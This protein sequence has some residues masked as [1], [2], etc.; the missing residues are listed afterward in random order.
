VLMPADVNGRWV[1]NAVMN[2][3][4]VFGPQSGANYGFVARAAEGL[5]IS[6][7]VITSNNSSG[8]MQKVASSGSNHAVLGPNCSGGAGIYT[9][10]DLGATTSTVF[11]PT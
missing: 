1:T 5:T 2:G 3:N 4:I 8:S 7:N 6:G 9:A 11:S 10:S